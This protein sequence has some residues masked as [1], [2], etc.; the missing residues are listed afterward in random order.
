MAME[1]P[2]NPP[3]VSEVSAES[4]LAATAELAGL[5]ERFLGALVDGLINVAFTLLAAFALIATGVIGSLADLNN[6]GLVSSVILTVAS[7]SFYIGI[8]WK[9]LST[10]GQT[11][12]KKVAKTRIV[13]MD[14]RV[15]S[16]VDLVAKR[17]AFFSL[18]SL[19]PVVGAFL[20]IINVLFIFGRERRCLHDLVAG[21]RV[22]K[23][24]PG[25]V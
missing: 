5:G 21:T 6:L 10:A 14:G 1:N 24:L 17:Y 12:G 16:M 20:S 9:F 23:A 25:A 13:T 4:P 15:P 22:I 19:I 3:T 7:F 8:N 18:I 2:Y 11:I